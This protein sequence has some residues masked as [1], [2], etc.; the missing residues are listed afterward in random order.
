[1]GL[2]DKEASKGTKQKETHNDPYI[3]T[4]TAR[5]SGADRQTRRNIQRGRM[6]YKETYTHT[7]R[8]RDR[9]AGRQVN[10]QTETDTD[11]DR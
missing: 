4:N 2:T 5:F 11:T 7:K 8:Q 9:P 1:V 6:A 10:I 3:H